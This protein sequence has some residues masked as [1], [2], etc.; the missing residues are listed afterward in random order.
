MVGS[1]GIAPVSSVF[2]TAAITRFANYPFLVVPRGIEPLFR[3]YRPRALPLDEGT[4][5]LILVL[6]EGIEPSL[7]R[8]QHRVLSFTLHTAYNYF[9]VS[10]RGRTGNILLLRQMPLPIGLTRHKVI[11]GI[12]CRT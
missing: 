2:Q 7:R 12:R 1:T 8:S 6:A 9:G 4:I 11:F 5:L 3:G 10:H